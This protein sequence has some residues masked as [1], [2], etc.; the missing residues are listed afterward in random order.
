MQGEQ[1]TIAHVTAPEAAPLASEREQK[2]AEPSMPDVPDTAVPALSAAAE[3][4]IAK[5]DQPKEASSS[6]A[7][8][9][10]QA[11]PT[12]EETPKAVP[13]NQ[14][15]Q[16]DGSAEPASASAAAAVDVTPSDSVGKHKSPSYV[17]ILVIDQ[18]FGVCA[19]SCTHKSSS[20]ALLSHPGN[21]TLGHTLIHCLMSISESVRLIRVCHSSSLCCCPLQTTRLPRL[22]R[23]RRHRQQLRTQQHCLL[24]TAM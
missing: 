14:A 6:P 10:A 3:S 15:D 22:P 9:P 17:H 16:K 5:D 8:Q 4:G 21:A 18:P 13:D 12:A 19:R 20:C 7:P 23:R 2:P 24:T 1:A 11:V